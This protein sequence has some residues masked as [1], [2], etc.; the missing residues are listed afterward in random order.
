MVC[1]ALFTMQNLTCLVGF[2]VLMACTYQFGGPSEHRRLGVVS[3]CR[4]TINLLAALVGQVN[5]GVPL[6]PV[7]RRRGAKYETEIQEAL[8]SMKTNAEKDG[9]EMKQ[10]E[11]SCMRLAAQVRNSWTTLTTASERALQQEKDARLQYSGSKREPNKARTICG[12]GRTFESTGSFWSLENHTGY[13][14]CHTCGILLC[15]EC[16]DGKWGKRTCRALEGVRKAHS[17]SP[18]GSAQSP[19]RVTVTR[20]KSI[21]VKEQTTG[22]ST[23][24]GSRNGT[25]QSRK[26]PEPSEFGKVMSKFSKQSKHLR[27]VENVFGDTVTG[28]NPSEAA[29]MVAQVGGELAVEAAF[30]ELN[31][32]ELPPPPMN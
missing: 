9:R 24:S 2:F 31:A 10:K 8:N 27:E 5:S 7:V 11:I 32:F 28:A 1:H 17:A 15:F 30:G 29:E 14:H 22:S 16:V 20:R 3:K 13:H 18:S 25:V 12:C 6:S 26:S 23:P 21:K 4:S 19:K